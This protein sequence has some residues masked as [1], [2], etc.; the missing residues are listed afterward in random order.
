[1]TTLDFYPLSY[2][3][4][5]T[6]IEFP[7][8]STDYK[9]IEA[10]ATIVREREKTVEINIDVRRLT[11][12]RDKSKTAYSIKELKNI[13]KALG[14]K[15]ASGMNKENLVKYIKLKLKK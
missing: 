2:P 9:T 7:Q 1:M 5:S 15:G 10:G 12:K 11:N 8:E 14:I 13:A 6:L 4:G 3:T